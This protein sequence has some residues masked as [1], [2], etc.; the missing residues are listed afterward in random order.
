MQ[1]GATRKWHRD[2]ADVQ[3]VRRDQVHALDPHGNPSGR[4]VASLIPL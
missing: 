3:N 2:F 1:E 4:M